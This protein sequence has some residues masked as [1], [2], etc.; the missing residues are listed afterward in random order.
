M[1]QVNRNESRSYLW[2]L[3]ISA[4]PCPVRLTPLYMLVLAIYTTLFKYF[5]SGPFWS[6]ESDEACITNWWTNLLYINNVVRQNTPVI[7][8]FV[9]RSAS[10]VFEI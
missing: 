6:K 2:L 5:G 1:S 4:S 8:V 10:N 7:V 3:L 9:L